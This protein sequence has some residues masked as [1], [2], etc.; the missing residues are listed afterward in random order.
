MP[1]AAEDELVRLRAEV[2]ALRG[3]LAGEQQRCEAAALAR[4]ALELEA[5]RLRSALTLAQG[6]RDVL[7]EQL[8][9]HMRQLREG[10]DRLSSAAREL[11]QL[12]GLQPRLEELQEQVG[13]W[14]TLCRAS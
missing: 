6:E 14:L 3:Q 8:A 13:D 4:D 12:Q 10:N 2:G 9:A 1:Q 7:S 11:G 5:G